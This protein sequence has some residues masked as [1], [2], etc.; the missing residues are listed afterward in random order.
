MP[1]ARPV[2]TAPR[3]VVAA[4]AALLAVALV[5]V[6]ALVAP[7][8]APARALSPA[9]VLASDFESGLGGWQARGAATVSTTSVGARGSGSLLVED[10]VDPWDGA[11]YPVTDLFEP[12]TT[13]TIGL[14]V[15]LP[16]GAGSADL[17]VSV[18]RD[19]DG[20]PSYE[21]VTTVEGVTSQWRQ[22]TGTYTPGPF[23]TA[24]LYVESVSSPVDVM[25]DDVL[26]TG[27]RYTPDLSVTPVSDAVSVPFGIAVEPQDLLGGRGD[28]LAHHAEQITPGNQMKP[29][30]I[31]PTEGT[32]TFGAADGLVD[33]ALEHD[34]RVYGHT[35]LWHQQTPAWFFQRDGSALTTSA[36]DQALLR[37][38]LRTHI[39]AIADHYRE[40]YG[41][42]GTPGNPIFAFDVVNEVIDENESDGLR[43]SE[44]YRVLGPSYIADAFRYAR[45]AFGP[46]VQLFINDYNSEYPDKRAP[47][48]RLVTDLLAQGV[49]VDGVGHQLHVEVGRSISM[50]EDTI[51]AFEALDVRQAVTELDVSAYR[52]SGE[53]WAAPPAARLLEQGYYYRDMFDMLERHAASFE[54]ITVWGLEDSRTWLRSGAAPLLFD[55]QLQ[56]KPAY[57]G[58]VDPSRIGTT[59]TPTP[60]STPTVTP[61][62]TPTAT[63]TPTPTPTATPTPT[64]TATPTPTPTATPTRTATPTPTPTA[65]A[66]CRVAYTTNDWNTGFTAGVRVTNA[67]PSALTGWTLTFA[68]AGGQRVTQGWSATWSQSGSTVTAANAA[69]NGTLAAGATVDV[70]FNGSH[71]GAN[72]RPTAFALNGTPCTV[73]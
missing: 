42:Y 11:L 58:I 35:L 70:G 67:G 33:W 26:V 5:G 6:G 44:W 36:A 50:I 10:R 17:R 12:G 41:E 71:T 23:D 60:T 45:D 16:D 55:G 8:V 48:L 32:F 14:W 21:T 18:Q 61:T 62:V 22:V 72:P 27:V 2:P 68:F 63:V 65:G 49:P 47:Y 7:L 73:S 25:I 52:D 30:A 69:W 3:P 1:S 28:L 15:R 39:E 54:S 24:S 31:Q 43:R 64:P 9:V 66:G 46:E 20:E 51:E 34:M 40:T 53:Q 4:L 37:E 56:V 38:R 29:D 57:W 19:L 59:P 13:Y